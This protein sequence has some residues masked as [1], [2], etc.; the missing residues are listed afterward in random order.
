VKTSM[1]DSMKLQSVDSYLH[2]EWWEGLPQHALLI[3]LVHPASHTPAS[4][5]WPSLSWYR[6]YEGVL[7]V[8]PVLVKKYVT[9]N[10][11]RFKRSFSPLIILCINNFVPRNS[12][13]ASPATADSTLAARSISWQ[14]NE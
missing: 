10:F 7:L 14:R 5:S 6:C 8:C 4:Q 11:K 3:F 1:D 12:D 13:A 9:F 2:Q